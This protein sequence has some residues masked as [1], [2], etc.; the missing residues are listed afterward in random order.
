MEGEELI[1]KAREFV[2]RK[3]KLTLERYEQIA[4]E[5]NETRDR[6]SRGEISKKECSK[7]HKEL[8]EETEEGEIKFDNEKDFVDFTNILIEFSAFKDS[9]KALSSIT[10]E[11]EH[12]KPWKKIGVKS[13]LGWHNFSEPSM[14]KA[15]HK[16]FGKEYEDLSPLEKNKIHHESLKVVSIPSESDTR[17]IIRLEEK[18]GKATNLTAR[19]KIKKSH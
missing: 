18:Y 6:R 9:S 13:Y 11:I 19:K 12:T 5:W 17:A 8:M 16:P 10:H 1:E 15:F 3:T 7:I 4:R 2:T 14:F